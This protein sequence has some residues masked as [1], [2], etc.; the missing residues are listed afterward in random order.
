MALKTDLLAYYK[1][2]EASGN[3]ADAT[4][5]GYTATQQDN[6]T[7]QQTG[8]IDYGISFDGTNDYFLIQEAGAL[9]LF[10]GASGASVS[11][12][13][14]I[15]E[16]AGRKLVFHDTWSGTSTRVR[17]EIDADEKISVGARDTSGATQRVKLTDSAVATGSFIHIVAVID[18][19]NDDI[20]IYVDGSPVASSGTT[21]FT[22]TSFA[23]DA[24]MNTNLAA[25]GDGTNQFKGTLDEM[26]IWSRVI[27]QTEVT[28][29]YNSGNG[30][31]YDDWDVG[32]EGTNTQINIGDDWKV[33][34]AMK[35][36]IS[37][38]WKAVAGAQINI[39]D[40]WKTIF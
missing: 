12:W 2:E 36:N 16:S 7:Y 38:D 9:D 29:I 18:I 14:N 25:L 33:V 1:M 40:A 4:G 35:I 10:G 32:E 26:A 31:S 27:S 24:S 22:E 34:D 37:D 6:P 8:K 28:E 11:V 17:V 21:T 30:L 23:A 5:N 15:T 39:G 19:A 3:L 13:V 20:I